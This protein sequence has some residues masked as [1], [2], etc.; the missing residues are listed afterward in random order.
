MQLALNPI[1]FNLGPIPLHWYGIIIASGVLLATILATR[2]G[3]RRGINP[4]N[5]YDMILWALPAALICARAYY[6]I[7]E[8]GYYSKHLDEIVRIWD[9]GIAIYGSLIGAMIMVIW[10]CRS[11]FISVWLMLDVAAPTVILGQAIGR[12]GNFMNQEAFG[13]VTNLAFLQSLH[14]PNWIINQMHV[15][16]LYRQPTFLYESVWSMLG[17][18]VLMTLRHNPKL[19]KQ[20]EIF[21]SYVMWYSFGRFFVEGM[22]TDS[23]MIGSL[24]VSQGLSILLFTGAL[25]IFIY[26]RL[27]DQNPW[28]LDGR[29]VNDNK[30]KTI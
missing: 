3:Q 17:F 7:F 25:A 12:W 21:L 24:R 14:L 6:V 8:W 15:N 5:I 10:Y 22:R 27:H 26:R 16:G 19:F 1:A 13:Q 18:L 2:E 29:N 23:L 20:G 11:H 9:G 30:E 4:D 28:Y